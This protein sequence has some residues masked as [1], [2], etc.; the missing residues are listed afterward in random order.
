M[1]AGRGARALVVLLAAVGAVAGVAGCGVRPT[2]LLPLPGRHGSHDDATVVTVQLANSRSLVRDSEVKVNDVTVGNV[3][4]VAFDNWH[5]RV[6]VSLDPGTVLPANVTARIAQKSLLGAE[7][8]ELAPPASGPP[9]GR[10][11]GGDV[12]PLARTSR[13]PDAEE[14]LAALSAVLNG[15]GLAQIAT[16]TSELDL[17]LGGRE[18]EVRQLIGTLGTF[19]GT[20]DAQR[21][22]IVRAIAGLDR[23]SGALNQRRDTLAHAVDTIPAGVRVLDDQRAQLVRALSALSDLGAVASRTIDGSKRDLIGN[24][25]DLQPAVGRLADAGADLTRS[26]SFLA[27]FPFPSNT[28]FPAMLKGDYANLYVTVDLSADN[29]A[30]NFGLGGL[31]PGIAVP[32]GRPS[33]GPGVPGGVPRV[34]PLPLP[35]APPSTPPLAPAPRPL[36]PVPLPAPAP[37]PAPRNDGLLGPALGGR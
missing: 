12:V 1:T 33:P 18:R 3:D 16:I 20:L 9:T 19:V 26:V 14:V 35:V 36:A 28:A 13:Y 22:G 8:L 27:T 31:F 6:T 30:R 7:Y 11:R 5:A 24:L 29:L 4:D 15:G 25:H 17:A 10:L 34:G 2:D 37:L 23:L 21:D 32:G